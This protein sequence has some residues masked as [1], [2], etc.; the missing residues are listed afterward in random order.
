VRFI[1]RSNVNG[2]DDYRKAEVS[3][4]YLKV[5]QGTRFVDSTYLNRLHQAKGEGVR[6]IGGYHFA[7]LEDAVAECDHFLS[8][9]V[10]PAAGEFKPC[11]DLEVG[12]AT[13]DARWADTW[14]MRFQ[15]KMG[16]LPV[17]YGNTSTIE[18]V[19]ADSRLVL[20]C[21]WWR[22]E[23]GPDDGRVHALVGGEMGAAAHQYTSRAQFPGI[24]GYTDAS[25]FCSRASQLVV[26][27]HHLAPIPG[28]AWA[29]AQWRLGIGR[30]K[31]HQGEARYRPDVPKFIPIS[32][33][34]AVA[35]YLTHRPAA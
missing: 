16:Y 22:A 19:R 12:S 14:I 1:D 3:W 8:L 9:I 11:L 25:V 18:Q 23:Y 30:F 26:P 13:V 7:N 32:W 29:W 6:V 20:R 27:S 33:W 5:S 10:H 34:R 24:A 17:V 31:G 21:P 2:A 15:E 28:A 35:W 4:I